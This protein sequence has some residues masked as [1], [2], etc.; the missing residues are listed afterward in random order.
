MAD[1]C[2]RWCT[3]G[4]TAPACAATR[5]LCRSV[6][7]EPKIWLVGS[8]NDLGELIAQGTRQPRR[9]NSAQA[10][11]DRPPQE[12]Q[13]LLQRAGSLLT[14]AGKAR[15]SPASRFARLRCRIRRRDRSAAPAWLPP[16][17]PGGHA[18][19]RVPDPAHTVGAPTALWA[20]RRLLT[21]DR[22]ALETPRRL[23]RQDPKSRTRPRP[24]KPNNVYSGAT[25]GHRPGPTG[26]RTSERQPSSARCRT[27]SPG[28]PLSA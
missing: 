3:G 10:E 4:R 5:A 19:R 27:H 26:A 23:H 12:L 9:R 25:G 13:P 28:T 24:R 21:T 2:G 7:S 17:R 1:R 16:E 20:A 8:E 15:L 6:L 11:L 22:N 18:R 14:D